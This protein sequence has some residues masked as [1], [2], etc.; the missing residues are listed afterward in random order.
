MIGS[1]VE[2]HVSQSFLTHKLLCDNNVA[3]QIASNSI[4]HERTKHIA[5]DCH[6]I[7]LQHQA[8]LLNFC[9]VTSH[10]QLTYRFTKARGS[11]QFNTLLHN[12]TWVTLLRVRSEQLADKFIK[13]SNANSDNVTELTF[14]IGFID[15]KLVYIPIEWSNHNQYRHM[16]YRHKHEMN[17]KKKKFYTDKR[18]NMWLNNFKFNEYKQSHPS[19]IY[20]HDNLY[21]YTGTWSKKTKSLIVWICSSLKTCYIRFKKIVIVR[22]PKDIIATEKCSNLVHQ[23]LSIEGC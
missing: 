20:C 18:K 2:R 10:K 1:L 5:V 4:F 3:I 14:I 16:H 23:E 11:E 19:N 12:I 7:H 21:K 13:F 9:H 22:H 8:K 15:M 6:Y 17:L